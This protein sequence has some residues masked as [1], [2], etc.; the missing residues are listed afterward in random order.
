MFRFIS[1]YASHTVL[2]T[3]ID[4]LR[5]F[6]GRSEPAGTAMLTGYGFDGSLP[7]IGDWGIP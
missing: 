5:E 2:L 6:T 4:F 7:Q 3:G 1:C